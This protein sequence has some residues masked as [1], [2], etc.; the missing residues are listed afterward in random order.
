MAAGSAVE[1]VNRALTL[2]GEDT[3]T[4]LTDD[5]S[6]ESS[7]ASTIY[8]S[9]LEAMLTEHPWRFAMKEG[10]LSQDAT[11]TR[12]TWQGWQ[13]RYAVPADSLAFYSTLQVAG[14]FEILGE[15]I[16][17]NQNELAGRWTYKPAPEKFPPH[18]QRALMFRL[19]GDLAIAITE[20]DRKVQAFG[21][22]ARDETSRA[23]AIEM[24]QQ[25]AM[26]LDDDGGLLSQRWG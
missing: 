10:L 6:V 12:A 14:D 21:R 23:H 20:D 7:I 26:R 18:F 13:Y 2:L 22:Q 15:F 3:V 16:Y 5:E 24:Q 19:A 1:Y 11:Y 17:S 9:T 8:D 4:S 25:P